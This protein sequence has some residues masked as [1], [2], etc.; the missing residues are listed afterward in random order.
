LLSNLTVAI[1]NGT[2]IKQNAKGNFE[3]LHKGK[4]VIVSPAYR[5]NRFTFVVSVFKTRKES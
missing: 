1:E 3:I 2:F 4:M 5:G